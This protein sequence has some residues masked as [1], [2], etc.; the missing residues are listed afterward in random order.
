MKQEMERNGERRVVYAMSDLADLMRRGWSRAES[1]SAE[2][3]QQ[4]RFETVPRVK[5]KYT[6]RRR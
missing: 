2:T 1:E 5:R 3:Q 4:E 6:K